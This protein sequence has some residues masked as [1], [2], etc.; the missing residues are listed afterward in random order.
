MGESI[1]DHRIVITVEVTVPELGQRI[2]IQGEDPLI[3][4]DRGRLA[5]H[6]DLKEGTGREREKVKFNHECYTT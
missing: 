4:V 5:H 6:P 1:I 3:I 2:A